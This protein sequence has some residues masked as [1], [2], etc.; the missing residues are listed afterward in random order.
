MHLERLASVI[1]TL[2]TMATDATKLKTSA[3]ARGTTNASAAAFLAHFKAAKAK[4]PASP[5]TIQAT[6][7]LKV[8]AGEDCLPG[9]HSRSM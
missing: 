7:K 4:V 6:P 1:T 8:L 9:A 5:E 2:L 3:K